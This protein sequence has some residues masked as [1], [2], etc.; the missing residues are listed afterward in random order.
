MRCCA[1]LV[2]R[3]NASFC[4]R[5]VLY[6]QATGRCTLARSEEGEWE[7][8]HPGRQEMLRTRDDPVVTANAMPSAIV[9]I[10]RRSYD[11]IM[12]I[13]SCAAIETLR[14][15]VA[16]CPDKFLLMAEA[17]VGKARYTIV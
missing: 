1:P 16:I 10:L 14:I 12:T 17:L 4:A 7:C 15:D 13:L 6:P 11:Y 3:L 8:L 9:E 2:S 5:N